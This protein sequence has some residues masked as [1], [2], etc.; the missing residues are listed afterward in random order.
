MTEITRVNRTLRLPVVVIYCLALLL[1]TLRAFALSTGQPESL[2]EFLSSYLVNPHFGADKTTRY[3]SALVHLNEHGPQ[4]VLVYVTGRTWCG[5]G[6]CTL[7]VL[8]E[9]GTSYRLVTRV[10]LARPPIVVFERTTNNW[11]DI[12][13]SV[14]GG[15]IQSGYEGAL[16]YNGHSYPSNPTVPPARRFHSDARDSV[17]IPVKA[18]G[19]LL[20]E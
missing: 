9:S 7:L 8:E 20:Y 1:A 15:G 17:V 3:V 13:V 6:G 19:N 2:R 4:D 12:G 10:K 14:Q 16:E 11:H 5:T 18:E